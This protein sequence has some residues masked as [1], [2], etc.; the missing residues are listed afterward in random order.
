MSGSQ[1]S[2]HALNSLFAL[3][4]IFVPR[5]YPPPPLHIVFLVV[6]LALY[7]ALA[8]ITHAAAGWYPYGFLDPDYGRGALAAYIVGILAAACVIF[9]IVWVVIWTRNKVTEKLGFEGK[10]ARRGA[11]ADGS[12]EEAEGDVV[13]L[14]EGTK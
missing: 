7:L 13:E 8:Y 9:G 4:E 6:L 5:T 1:I 2:E 10:F 11:R 12:M 3:F 14:R